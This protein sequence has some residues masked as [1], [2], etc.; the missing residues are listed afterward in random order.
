VDYGTEWKFSP[1]RQVRSNLSSFNVT[2]LS[3]SGHFWEIVSS[4]HQG[5]PRVKGAGQENVM[6]KNAQ[7][8]RIMT[9]DLK[10]IPLVTGGTLTFHPIVQFLPRPDLAICLNLFPRAKTE[11]VRSLLKNLLNTKMK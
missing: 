10:C 9:A 5:I 8:G 1:F 4:F 2:R 7:S 11:W 3:L 6:M